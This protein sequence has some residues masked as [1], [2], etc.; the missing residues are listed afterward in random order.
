[1]GL[2]AFEFREM[3]AHENETI[4]IGNHEKG[5]GEKCQNTQDRCLNDAF[6]RRGRRPHFVGADLIFFKAP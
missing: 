1:M 3:L 2:G 4:A 5:D 6:A